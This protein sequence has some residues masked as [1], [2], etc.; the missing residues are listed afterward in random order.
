[1]HHASYLPWLEMGRTELLREASVSYAQLEE[2]G[3]FLVVVKLD[4]S[5][6]RPALYD[7]LVEVRTRVVGSS[8][9]KLRHQYEIWRLED[10]AGNGEPELLVS[11]STLLASIDRSGR[12]SMMPDWL[13][14]LAPEKPKRNA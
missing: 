13:V 9:V 12:P 14:S 4:C 1:M 7:E 5:Y 10:A 6:K 3:V 11:A 2:A 8:R